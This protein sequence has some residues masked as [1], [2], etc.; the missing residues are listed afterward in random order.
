MTDTVSHVWSLEIKMPEIEKP[1]YYQVKVGNN[2]NYF[3][4]NIIKIVYNEIIEAKEIYINEAIKL[5][6]LFTEFD[7]NEILN[8]PLIV[9]EIAEKDEK[10]IE[11]KE[12]EIYENENNKTLIFYKE[13]T[14]K[15]TLK[16]KINKLLTA[17]KKKENF[18]DKIKNILGDLFNW[19]LNRFTRK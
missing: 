16:N 6:E 4:S 13:G 5:T 17:T 2:K 18:C 9:T 1:I 10:I 3:Y 14:Y 12:N 7:E 15:I 11:D 8:T 19:I